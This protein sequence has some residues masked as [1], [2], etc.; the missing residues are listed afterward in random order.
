M[1]AGVTQRN[2]ASACF[3]EQRVFGRPSWPFAFDE[4]SQGYK[5]GQAAVLTGFYH[6]LFV[7]TCWGV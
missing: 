4:V 2:E 6:N 5:R 3:S 7:E 1:Q